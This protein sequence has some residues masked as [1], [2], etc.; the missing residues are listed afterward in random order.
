[1]E[2]KEK[3]GLFISRSVM[4]KFRALIQ[5]KYEKYEKGLLSYEAE[6]AFRNWLALHTNAQ[7]RLIKPN[8]KPK[9]AL[10][11]AQVKE[12]LASNY[13][14]DSITPGQQVPL[15]HLEN[16]IRAIRGSDP[17]TIKKWLQ[18]FRKF[19]LIKPI[20]GNLWEVL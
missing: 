4:E 9:V 5:Q 20:T 1:M 16:A 8:P 13:Y 11:F 15:T 12:F 2:E 3:V 6:L 14:F 19:K 17:R 18:A 7:T 10:V